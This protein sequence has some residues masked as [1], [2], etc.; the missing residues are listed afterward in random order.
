MGIRGATPLML[1]L[2]GAVL[3][4]G[5]AAPE[6]L[7]TVKGRLLFPVG[8]LQPAPSTIQVLLLLEDGSRR[9][10]FATSNSSFAFQRVPEGR[11]TLEPSCVGYMFPSL[12]VDVLP[13]GDI[14]TAYAEFP[15]QALPPPLLIR[16]AQID[17]FDKVVPF[18]LMGFLKSPMG[19]LAAFMLFAVVVMPMLKVDPEEME[20]Y[21]KEQQQELLKKERA[22]KAAAEA[23]RL[24]APVGA[25]GGGVRQRKK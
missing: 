25:T 14:R 6:Q 11:H 21:K 18:N 9:Q 24:G 12:R 8:M 13:G 4:V 16:A 22:V 7:H 10:T 20:E 3:A 1:A 15:E 5:A 2:L 23:A 19:M 17:Y